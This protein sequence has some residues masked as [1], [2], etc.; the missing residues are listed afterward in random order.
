MQRVLQILLAERVPIKDLRSILEVL[1]EYAQINDVEVLSEYVRTAL[2]RSI[3]NTLLKDSAEQSITVMTIDGTLE[4]MMS[5]SIQSTPSGIMVGLDQGITSE[6]FG[7]LTKLIDDMIANGQHPTVLASPQIRLAF[8]KLTVA[9]FP[10]LNIIS[11][12]EIAPDVD[13]TSIGTITLG[14]HENTQIHSSEYAGSA[15]TST[16]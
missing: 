2:R 4:N 6:M 3:C 1:S 11:Y 7:V 12:N 13:I 8:R 5:E 14:E 16:G 15:P 10:S 9:N